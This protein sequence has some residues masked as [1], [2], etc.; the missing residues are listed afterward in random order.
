MIP[1]RNPTWANQGTRHPLLAHHINIA[2]GR[3]RK[4]P[5]SPKTP[6]SRH[7]LRYVCSP[8]GKGPKNIP[9]TNFPTRRT[10]PT[11]TRGAARDPE[12]TRGDA[13]PCAVESVPTWTRWPVAITTTDSRMGELAGTAGALLPLA[14]TTRGRWRCGHPQHPGG[15]MALSRRPPLAGQIQLLSCPSAL[16]RRGAC[17]STNSAS[18]RR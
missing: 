16:W 14:G 12:D 5:P 11:T 13:T 6:S 8:T 9:A 10:M 15:V 18:E 2:L 4:L 3:S 7:R 17:T 1:Q